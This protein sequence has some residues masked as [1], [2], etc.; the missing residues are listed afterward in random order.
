MNDLLG[1][2]LTI[3]GSTFQGTFTQTG[4]ENKRECF[5]VASGL[6]RGCFCGLSNVTRTLSFPCLGSEFQAS[7]CDVSI[8]DSMPYPLVP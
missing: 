7:H 2:C 8:E 5:R 6:R 1:K 4:F 3:L